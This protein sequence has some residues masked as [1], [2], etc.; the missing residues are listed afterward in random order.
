V[1]MRRGEVRWYKFA[2]PDKM[3]PVVILTR[4]SIIEYLGET[5]VAPIT[6]VIRDIPSE[7]LLEP[8][9]GLP[10]QCAVNCDHVQTV[11]RAKLGAVITTLPDA[12]MA[13]IRRALLF[14]LGM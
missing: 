4:N 14:A 5:T 12:V 13:D 8:H 11:T 1:T 2:A 3:R 9:H 7:V 6:T 10:R